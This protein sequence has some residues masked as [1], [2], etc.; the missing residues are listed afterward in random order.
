MV[1]TVHNPDQYMYDFK[2]IVGHGRKKIG[3]LVGAGAPVGI[4]TSEEGGYKP[5][6]PDVA[7]LTGIVRRRL[8]EAYRNCFDEIVSDMSGGN[9]E[10]VLSRIRSFIEVLGDNE[11][12]GLNSDAYR[13][14]E[15]EVCEKIKDVVSVNLPEKITL[16]RIWY[17]G[18]MELAVTMQ[19]RFLQQTTTSLLRKPWSV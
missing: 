1:D 12:H 17:R 4:N 7:G 11:I 13:E 5:L 3:L 16:T 6:I 2:Q 19:L 15:Q 10:N 8:S 18:S 9:I 14:F